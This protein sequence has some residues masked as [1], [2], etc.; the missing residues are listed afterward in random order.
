LEAIRMKSLIMGTSLMLSLLFTASCGPDLTHPQ[1]TVE[2]TTSEPTEELAISPTQEIGSPI[3]TTPS[4]PPTWVSLSEQGPWLAFGGADGTSGSE[5][6]YILDL[7]TYQIHR[8]TERDGF[9]RDFYPYDQP[10]TSHS[11][12]YVDVYEGEPWISQMSLPDGS[13][14][15][16]T[17]LLREKGDM[18]RSA[19]FDLES[20]MQQRAAA[21]WQ[22]NRM[23]FIGA[24]DGPSTDLYLYEQ[25]SVRRL[26]DEPRAVITEGTAWSWSP[27]NIY[28]L[29]G[30]GRAYGE[31]VDGESSGCAGRVIEVRALHL[32]VEQSLSMT[33]NNSSTIDFIGWEP[34]HT[35]L[36]SVQPEHSCGWSKIYQVDASTGEQSLIWDGPFTGA[37]Y[38]PVSNTTLITQGG[39]QYYAQ[40]PGG[41]VLVRN[42][43]THTLDISVYGDEDTIWSE[44]LGLFLVRSDTDLIGITPEG[45]VSTYPAPDGWA[46]F[47]LSPDG[48]WIIWSSSE[49]TLAGAWGEEPNMIV[50]DRIW[51]STWEPD[52][53]RLY[54]WYGH[55]LHYADPPGFEP[56]FVAP[57]LYVGTPKPL[58]I[59]P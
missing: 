21:T 54:L 28:L 13:I 15:R 18:D 10:L 33:P 46:D 51:Q 56:V 5:G 19:Y 1:S 3:P 20:D 50:D 52:G 26:T 41:A 32:D 2:I 36:L 49:T 39:S 42:G 24:L 31:Y 7:Q 12:T 44:V 53:E 23:V 48:R 34:P 22:G 27:D 4:V 9:F 6:I 16:I 40:Q 57:V 38:D 29:Y 8:I 58:W 25:G 47:T 45:S 11:I 55:G 14:T 37:A 35:V 43:A 30:L 17:K 59:M